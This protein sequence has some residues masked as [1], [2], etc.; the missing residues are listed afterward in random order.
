MPMLY[1]W[2]PMQELNQSFFFNE[3]VSGHEN[4]GGIVINQFLEEVTI[5]NNYSPKWR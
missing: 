5:V 3:S 1:V 4:L 2:P